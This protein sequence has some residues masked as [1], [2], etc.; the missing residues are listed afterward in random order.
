MSAD[1]LNKEKLDEMLGHA[2]RKHTEQ[3]PADFTDKMLRQIRESQ[4]QKIL[5]RVVLEERLALAGCIVLVIIAIAAPVV[6]P[7]IAGSLTQQVEGFVD[8]ISKAIETIAWE[9]NFYTIFMGAFGFAVYYLAYLLT[10]D[11]W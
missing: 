11:G 1:K 3:V 9:L 2:L 8:K 7:S 5:A 6:L 4:E 10:G